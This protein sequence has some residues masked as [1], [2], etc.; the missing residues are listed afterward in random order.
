MEA[1]FE[2]LLLRENRGLSTQ[3][4][5]AGFDQFFAPRKSEFHAKWDAAREREKKGR[6]IFAH[7]TISADEVAAELQR[8]REAIGSGADVEAFVIDSVRQLGGVIAGER[9]LQ[10]DFRETPIA[11]LDAVGS[12]RLTAIFDGSPHADEIL[13]TRTHPIVA[14]LASYV[15]ESAMDDA[16]QSIASRAGAL[17]TSKIA[18]RTTLLLTRMRF[19]LTTRRESRSHQMLAEDVGLLAFQGSVANAQW[20]TDGEAAALLAL[21][22]EANI[23]ADR[24]REVVGRV[25]DD[26]A[27]LRPFIDADARKRAGTLLETHLRVRG[28]AK[29]T[30]LA[31]AVEPQ[32]PVDILGIFVFI[33][34]QG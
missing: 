24:V 15:F 7:E 12:D 4:K 5:L 14:A 10:I 29:L 27:T 28:E 34:R 1:V 26:F 30:G 33:P 8:V 9:P 32:L 13:L 21:E 11:V 2:G 17:F 25:I 16:H 23:G 31:F 19:H 18:T 6:S 3:G 20:L 22:P